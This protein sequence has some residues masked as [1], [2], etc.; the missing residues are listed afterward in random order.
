MAFDPSPGPC[1]FALGTKKLSRIISKAVEFGALKSILM[2]TDRQK[3]FHNY[4]FN[5]KSFIKK[6]IKLKSNIFITI[7]KSL[8]FSYCT[9]SFLT[10]NLYK[11]IKGIAFSRSSFHF[12]TPS[13]PLYSYAM[14]AKFFISFSLQKKRC[15]PRMET[16]LAITFRVALPV[17]CLK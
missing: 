9:A 14:T 10:I 11:Y 13:F 7:Y 1:I 16:T 4:I 12:D 17:G 2:G 8:N 15:P 3:L 6:I 5:S